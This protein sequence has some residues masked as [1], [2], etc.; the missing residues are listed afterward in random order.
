MRAQVRLKWVPIIIRQPNNESIRN[1]YPHSPL[2]NII[3]CMQNADTAHEQD[4]VYCLEGHRAEKI[5]LAPG[6]AHPAAR[7]RLWEVELAEK[8]EEG[9]VRAETD[10]YPVRVRQVGGAEWTVLRKYCDFEWLFKVVLPISRPSSPPT[11][12]SCCPTSPPRPSSTPCPPRY[13]SVDA[14][15]VGP[16]VGGG[17]VGGAAGAGA[18]EVR[19]G[20]GGARGAGSVLGTAHFRVCER[21]R[22]QTHEKEHRAANGRTRLNG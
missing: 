19:A 10:S 18:G 20:G 4:E 17:D 6:E 1:D 16:G 13:W 14:V 3:N 11:P 12:D 15:G 9:L 21:G 8:M 7:G 2:P 5:H 22:I